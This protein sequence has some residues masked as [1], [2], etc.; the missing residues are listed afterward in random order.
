VHQ[1]PYPLQQQGLG[2]H[3]IDP[4][5]LCPPGQYSA[6]YWLPTEADPQ[7]TPKRSRLSV[8]LAVIVAVVILSSGAGSY[9]LVAHLSSAGSVRVSGS[10]GWP[11]FVGV[12]SLLLGAVG[13]L[14]GRNLP[15]AG[16]RPRGASRN[17]DSERPPAGSWRSLGRGYLDALA[18]PFPHREPSS[19]WLATERDL[20]TDLRQLLAQLGADDG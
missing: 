15:R 19:A 10:W 13:Y 7:G 20:A 14:A 3:A 16:S 17:A 2:Q 1:Q 5:G 6:P 4:F 18:F 8:I 11:V 9:L 12:L